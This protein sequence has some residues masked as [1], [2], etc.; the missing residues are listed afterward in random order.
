MFALEA[1]DRPI[2]AELTA[3]GETTTVNVPKGDFVPVG[4]ADVPSGGKQSV[5]VEIRING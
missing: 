4:E 1:A 5:L 3:E 2:S